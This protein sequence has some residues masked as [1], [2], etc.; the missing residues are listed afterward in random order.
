MARFLVTGGAGFIGSHLVEALL[1]EGHAVRVLD[2][3]PNA[4]ALHSRSHDLQVAGLVRADPDAL[5]REE[6]GT[7]FVTDDYVDYYSG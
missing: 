5:V 1:N 2:L 7:F 6:F 3:E 4:G